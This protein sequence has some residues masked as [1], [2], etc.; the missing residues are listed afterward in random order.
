MCPCMISLKSTEDSSGP[1]IAIRMSLA[2]LVSLI[3]FLSRD[4]NHVHMQSPV[5]D[6][7][8]SLQV[9]VVSQLWL[10]L[11]C[12]IPPESISGHL[13]SQN[14]SVCFARTLFTTHKVPPPP[15]PPRTNSCMKPCQPSATWHVLQCLQV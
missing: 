6:F 1:S 14:V 9:Q 11:G 3:V 10:M 4:F 7:T 13:H 2:R 15:P 5:P 8:G 12:Q